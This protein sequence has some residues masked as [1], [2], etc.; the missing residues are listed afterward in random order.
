MDTLNIKKFKKNYNEKLNLKEK[1]QL[2]IEFNRKI[3]NCNS[4]QE[5]LQIIFFVKSIMWSYNYE[6]IKIST[7]K[8]LLNKNLEL[9]FN[10]YD[11]FNY[12]VDIFQFINHLNKIEINLSFI[13]SL[14]NIIYIDYISIISKNNK[15]PE[16]YPCIL[17]WIFDYLSYI[18]IYPSSECI[19]KLRRI[20]YERRYFKSFERNSIILDQYPK[21]SRQQIINF[22]MIKNI[23]FQIASIILNSIDKSSF[24]WIDSLF[25]KEKYLKVK[26]KIV[27]GTFI[28]DGR[29][30]YFKNSNNVQFNNIDLK[31]IIFDM[32]NILKNKT[33]V[34]FVFH[35]RHKDILFQKCPKLVDYTIFTPFDKDDDIMTLYLWLINPGTIL[36]SKDKYNNYAQK[37]KIKHNNYFEEFWLRWNKEFKISDTKFKI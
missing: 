29:N 21:I 36:I 26:K 18:I 3:M 22:K 17:K 11:I 28:I 30:W 10:L 4:S 16:V 24:K 15:I 33:S 35:R 20:N 14:V 6:F 7:I 37:L 2:N 13:E 23:L 34:V 31:R 1:K 19:K 9:K 5:F 8:L 12:S 27:S 25:L 32:Q